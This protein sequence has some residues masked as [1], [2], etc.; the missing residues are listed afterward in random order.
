M[1]V[2]TEASGSM[3]SAYLIKSIQE[4][5]QIAVASDVDLD[6][7]AK[8]IANEFIQMP[9][10]KDPELWG[11]IKDLLKKNKID[12]VIPS[13]DETLYGWALNAETF[14]QAG[15]SIIL[16][17]KETIRIFQDKWLTYIFFRDNE[18]PCPN[19]SLDQEFE[20]IKPRNG[21][22]SQG[23]FKTKSKTNMD[24]NISQHF[25]EGTE[26]TID[27]FC[28][29]YSNPVYIVPRKRKHIKDGKSTAGIVVKHENIE[30]WVKQICSA[31]KFKGPINIQCIEEED[32]EIKFIEINPRIAGGMALGF[33]ATE[34]WISLIISHFINGD[35]ISPQQVKYGLKMKRYYSEAFFY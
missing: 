5:G 21:R 12:I 29:K 25:V 4:A 9:P 27:V 8:Q 1:R 7:Y 2:L 35:E 6:C 22:G 14:N 16:S 20:L 30:S 23:I 31:I 32:G 17:E 24:G 11:K 18:I 26:Y 33:A 28:D 3:I 15:V 19:T 13:L 34:N 10:N